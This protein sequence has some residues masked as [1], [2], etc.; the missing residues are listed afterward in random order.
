MWSVVKMHSL[1]FGQCSFLFICTESQG[2][3]EA[4]TL[5][6]RTR[7][8]TRETGLYFWIIGYFYLFFA[9]LFTDTSSL[10]ASKDWIWVTSALSSLQAVSKLLLQIRACISNISTDF[11]SKFLPARAPVAGGGGAGAGEAALWL[12]VC[13]KGWSTD[14]NR[15]RGGKIPK[16]WIWQLWCPTLPRHK[17]I[18]HRSWTQHIVRYENFVL[19]MGQGGEGKAA[20]KE[21]NK[22]V[23]SEPCT[24]D[25]RNPHAPQYSWNT[26]PGL[27]FCHV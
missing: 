17:R 20:E 15:Q 25:I 27:R 21:Q 8:T 14:H 26:V 23:S 24:W 13:P 2:G 18:R 10:G 6:K 19:S 16:S 3:R 9:L 12:E 7:A 11:C 5:W 1:A 4:A 22:S